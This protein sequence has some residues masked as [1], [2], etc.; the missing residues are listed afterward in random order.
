M[1]M[2][3]NLEALLA[4]GQETALLRFSLGELYLKEGDAAHAANHLAAAV[5]LDADYSAAWKLYG[6]ALAAA[7]RKTEALGAYEKGIAVAERRGDLQAAKEMRVFQKR[8]RKH[9]AEG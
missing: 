8:L 5:A 6:R 9:P 4:K 2:R 7:G 1:G 3:E